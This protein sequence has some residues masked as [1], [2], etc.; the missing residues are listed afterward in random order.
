MEANVREGNRQSA[1][2]GDTDLGATNKARQWL[3]T[4]AHRLADR[5]FV[6]SIDQQRILTHGEM[7]LLANQISNYLTR[8]GI[9]ANDRVALLANNSVEHLIVYLAV[10]AHGAVICTINVEANIAYLS[11][12]MRTL[13][14]RLIIDERELGLDLPQMENCERLALGQW[15]GEQSTGL[16]AELFRLPAC[17][18]N[19]PAGS[20]GDDAC[21]YFTS[22]TSDRP[23]GVILSQKELFDNVEP[24][25][26]AFGITERDRIL[27]FRSFNW[28]S[29][30]ILSALVPLSRGATLV[31]ARKFSQSNYFP[32]IRDYGATIATGN[33]TIINMMLNR[34]SPLRGQD[35]PALRFITSSSAPLLVDEWQRFEDTYQI[36][37]A[38]GYG[39]SETGW[40][41]GSNE[42]TRRIGSVGKP[43][44]YHA[45]KIVN[46]KGRELDAGR[47]GYV[48]LGGEAVRQYRYL[49]FDGSI[50]SHAA[51]RIRTGDLGYLDEA[52]YLYLTGREKELIIRGGVNIA[53]V[54]IDGVLL[55]H[56]GVAEAATIGVP[57]PIWGEEVLSF[58]VLKLG[59]DAT[60]EELL[61][62]ASTHLPAYKA[63]KA[64]ILRD[65]LPK[66]ARGKL[67]RKAIADAWV[68]VDVGAF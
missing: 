40:I 55:G 32:W 35:M 22:G 13:K 59:V 61:D 5:P 15:C 46:A 68:K 39:S 23:K 53:P 27:D 24:V 26:E 62:H 14:P 50:C 29:A 9:G 33:P 21:I 30:Q 3:D 51:G 10:L 12:L 64:I 66:T 6:E 1:T 28:A 37:I 31:L 38:Q 48:E 67:D 65:S 42:R 7:A 44:T 16:F 52:G 54:E 19:V 17:V 58:V 47:I 4:N 43:L 11:E 49:S 41:S 25:A 18:P 60:P 36:R 2:L 8:C 20:E 45:L 57:D 63:P 56:A 34:P